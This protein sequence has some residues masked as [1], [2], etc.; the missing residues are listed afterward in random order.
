[1]RALLVRVDGAT[2]EVDLPGDKRNLDVMY[3]AMKCSRVDVVRIVEAA[4]GRPGLD[5]WIDDDGLFTKS[6][7]IVASAIVAM[8][9][10]R[11]SEYY[12]GDVLFTGGADSE[13]DTLSLTRMQGEILAE[14]AMEARQR[15]GLFIA[16]I[17]A[18]HP[19]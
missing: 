12:F 3:E 18:A 2:E 17:L 5:M 8:I 1:M 19:G 10:G 16:Q 14:V 4:P 6:P 15:S 9:T 13:G 7:N 11:A